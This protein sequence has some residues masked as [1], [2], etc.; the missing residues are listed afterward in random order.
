MQPDTLLARETLFTGEALGR[1]A[2]VTGA[3]RTADVDGRRLLA[4]RTRGTVTIAPPRRDLEPFNVLAVHLKLAAPFEG[5]M[6]TR[7]E[8]T[9]RSPGMETND[10][11]VSVLH[12]NQPRRWTGWQRILLPA[13]N[14]VAIGFPDR[15]AHVKSI[16]FD[17]HSRSD[18]GEVIFGDVELL[19]VARPAGPRMTDAELLEALDLDRPDL[20]RVA[21]HARAGRVDRAVAALAGVIRRTRRPGRMGRGANPHYAATTAEALCRHYIQE[22]QLPAAIDWHVN[23]IGY[24]EWNH[25]FNRHGWMTTLADAFF[26]TDS[27]ARKRKYAGKLDYFI[28]SWCEQNPEPIGHNGGLDPAWETLSTSIRINWAWEH[29][30]AVAAASDAVAD[31]TLIDM[32]KMIHAHAEHLLRY[33]GHCNWYISESAAILTCGVLVPQFRR[34]SDWLAAG[35]RRLSREMTVQVF[36]DGAQYELSPGYHTMCAQLLYQAYTRAA[37][38]GRDFPAAYTRRLWRMHDYLATLARPDGTYPVPNDAGCTL[39]AGNPRLAAVGRAE[40][41][42]DWLWAGTA[43]KE[44]RPPS[45]GSIHFPDAGYAVQRSGWDRDARWAFIDMAEFGAA[46]QHEDKL[47]V[48]LHAHGTT[49]LVDPGISSYQHDPVVEHFRTTCAHNTLTI[50]TLGQV[51]RRS[52]DYA[53]Y[54]RSSRGRNL[55]AAGEGLDFAQGTYDEPYGR[56][57]GTHVLEGPAHTRALVFVRPDYWLILDSVTGRGTH[58]VEALWHFAPMLVRADA[59]AA[60]LR[61][62]RLTHANLELLCRG[63]WEGGTVSVVTGRERPSVQ[64]FVALDGEIKPAPCGIASVTAALPLHGVTVAVPFATG[65]ESHV[66]AAAE[67]VS[68]GRGAGLLVTVERPGGITDRFLWRHTGSGALAAD[69]LRAD[70]RLAAVR[71]SEDGTVTWAALMDGA[72]LRAGATTLKGAPGRLVERHA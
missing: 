20:R 59:K 23:P 39:S 9:T 8:H 31:R 55:W 7:M 29:V 57:G 33:W 3:G 4:V 68:G 11:R 69:G 51:R 22:Q 67:P 43:G 71:T 52:G 21:A 49:F 1:Q 25:A 44:G 56:A 37:F 17:V 41:R 10:S 19:Q 61:T 2:A 24:L 13:E 62:V 46:H 60:T 14:L 26:A 28:R 27:A 18:C 65:T 64:G 47:H 35:I 32:A 6:S 54:S 72:S 70:G 36:P 48:S 30:L 66:R 42:P 40:K 63:G 58:T 15:W 16:T 45:A 5:S 38:A 53:R 50:D 34:A 12:F